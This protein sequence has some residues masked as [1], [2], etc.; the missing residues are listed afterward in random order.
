MAGGVNLALESEGGS[1]HLHSDTQTQTKT[2]R[3]GGGILETIMQQD[4]NFKKKKR[5]VTKTHYS[6]INSIILVLYF[7]V[8]DKKVT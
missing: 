6:I 2:S 1:S 3:W 8:N 5:N 7:L 4:M